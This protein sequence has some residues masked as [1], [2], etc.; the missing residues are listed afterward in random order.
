MAHFLSN[1]SLPRAADPA[2][3]WLAAF[4]GAVFSGWSCARSAPATARIAI[5]SSKRLRFTMP[6]HLS[7]C[8]ANHECVFEPFYSL[9]LAQQFPPLLPPP[10]FRCRFPVTRYRFL[11]CTPATFV[12]LTPAKGCANYGP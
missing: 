7:K 5:P 6:P 12:L 4:F 9:H 1:T 11:L 3:A 10:F 2:E 8:D